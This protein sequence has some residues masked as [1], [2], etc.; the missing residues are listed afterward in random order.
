MINVLIVLSDYLFSSFGLAIVALT[1]IT[2]GL[3]YPLTIKQLRSTKA[4]QALQPKLA[5]LQKKHGK[6]KN[7][8][9]R[10]QM[11]LY[12]ESGVSPA[13][14]LLPMLVQMPIWIALFWSIIK[15]LAANPEDFLGLSRYLYSWPIVYSVVP[16]ILLRFGK[17]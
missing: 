1:I 16:L 10:E 8:M 4:M 13:G 5:E 7:K 12:K 15:L 9:A 11:R 3:M 17:A 14:C 2:R 6:D